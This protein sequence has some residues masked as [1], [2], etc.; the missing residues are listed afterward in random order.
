MNLM[1]HYINGV[2]VMPANGDNIGIR[3]D[4]T[5]DAKEAELNV[6]SIVLTNDAYSAVMSHLNGSLGLFEGIPY[7]VEIGGLQLDYFIDLTEGAK[8]SDS[9]VEV[10]IKKRRAVDWFLTQA[11]ATSFELINS[12]QP[13][14]GAFNIPY[15]IV[16]D[17]QLELLVMLSLSTYTLTKELIEATKDLI[18]MVTSPTIEASTPNAGVP[19]SMNLG[20]IIT[21]VLKIAAQLVY[22]LAIAAALYQTVSQL[23]ELI[24]PKVRF[25][26][27]NKVKDLLTQGCN[28]LGYKFESNLL[29]NLSGLTVLPVP[30]VQNNE[31]IFDVLIGNSTTAYNKPYP[32]ASDSVST[33]GALIEEMKKLGNATLKVI[34]DT[35]YL[36]RWDYWQNVSSQ[37]FINTM[38]LQERRENEYTYN[39]AECWKRYYLHY[40]FDPQ[41]THT[42]DK[43]NGLQSEHS[44]EPVNTINS[45]IVLIKGLV[46]QSLDFS[47]G[48]RKD[49][50][51]FVEK[52]ALKVAQ[53]CDSVVSSLGGS[54]SLSQKVNARI[55]VLQISQQ[56]FS[57]TKLMYV[58]GNRQPP[59]YLDKIGAPALYNN[60]HFI[61]QID[62]N[63]QEISTSEIPFAP[64]QIEALIE[65]NYIFDQTGEQYKIL[66][67]EWVNGSQKANVEYSK[68]SNKG[69]NT[70]TIQII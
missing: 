56:Y 1:K 58:V 16:K 63:L 23:I 14:T 61:N 39:F 31:S 29:D 30:L 36:E 41:D 54:S 55:G 8:F 38:N 52:S 6:D 48:Y 26:N 10:K 28:F 5:G 53:L 62:L 20:A 37:G 21:A 7:N 35:V 67:F 9:Q 45:D 70:K 66:T 60:Y 25:L 69:T 2:E 44:T 34:G 57:K 65:N 59:D 64:K 15:V 49:K 22:T 3:L 12:K 27:G 18:T 42:M 47:I 19:P 4:F 51:T 40:Q 13:I 11:R 68:K 50:L 17:N 43:L 46:D 32:S 24:C 33:L